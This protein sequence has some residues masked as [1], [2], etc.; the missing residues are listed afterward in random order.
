MSDNKKPQKKSIFSHIDEFYDSD[1]DNEQQDKKTQD[2]MSIDEET[3]FDKMFNDFKF[4]SFNN[5]FKHFF[6]EVPH[7]GEGTCISRSYVSST[8]YN[9]KGEPETESYQTQSIKHTDKDGHRINEKQ[10]AYKNS[11]SGV[12]KVSHQTMLDGKGHKI[13]QERNKKTGKKSQHD[14]YKKIKESDLDA[15]NKEYNDYRE[16]THF[17]NKYKLFGQFDEHFLGKKHD[18]LPQE[19]KDE[20][21]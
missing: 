10:E 13:I 4:P 17:Q 14:L 9:E 21:K 18:A 12:E 11:L 16:K 20:K 3:P 2:L 5:N 19:K 15:F 6:Q 1:S 7:S 8:K